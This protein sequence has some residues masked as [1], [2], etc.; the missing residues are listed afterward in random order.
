LQALPALHEETPQPAYSLGLHWQFPFVTRL[1]Y[2]VFIAGAASAY[3]LTVPFGISTNETQDYGAQMWLENEF[4][5]DTTL[6]QC[7]RFCDHPTFDSAGVY[8]V[9]QGFRANYLNQC[10]SPRYPGP[11]DGGF[12]HDP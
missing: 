7:T 4:P 10:Y 6:L 1:Q 5:L 12:P 11:A 8:N 3:S 2:E 9:T